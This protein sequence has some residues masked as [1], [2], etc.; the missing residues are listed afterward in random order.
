MSKREKRTII[1]LAGMINMIALLII[2]HQDTPLLKTESTWPKHENLEEI[3]WSEEKLEEARKFY[4]SLGSTA[5]M[6]IYDGK[7]LFSW[8]NTSQKSNVHSIRKS[9]LSALYGIHVQ[10]GTI[11]LSKTLR[12]LGIE[13]R[14][15]LTEME[16]EAQIEDLLTSRS[17]IFLRA[18]EESL[19]MRWRR[20]ERELHLPGS[21]F[22]YNNWD[23]NVLGTIFNNLTGKDLFDEFYHKI[24]LPLGM[25]DFEPE[26]GSYKYELRR[27]LHP[28]YLFRMSAR[29]MARFGQLYLQNGQ[30][31]GKQIIPEEWVEVSTQAHAHAPSS[32]EYGYGYMWWVAE[33]EFADVGLYSAVGRYGQSIDIVPEKN[34]VFVHRVNSDRFFN[35]TVRYVSSSQRLQ[36]LSMILDAKIEPE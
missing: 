9:Y 13:D 20:P 23:F 24:A 35:R 12:E 8:G 16:K 4:R 27:S 1:I 15:A 7:V 2:G 33:K 11:A 5:A 30:W 6:A 18:G 32:N 19:M 29:D 36:L 10:E 31:E 21:Y 26:D 25:E 28:S 22:Y 17:G 34:L 14:V 3:G